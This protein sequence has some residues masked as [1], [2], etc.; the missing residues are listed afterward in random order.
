MS[1]HRG[2]ELH[3]AEIEGESS[4]RRAAVNC[5]VLC[6]QAIRH[7]S[8]CGTDK[9]RVDFMRAAF[10]CFFFLTFFE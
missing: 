4:A 2:V 3:R 9:C 7:F 6:L 5:N 8:D 1:K 10:C